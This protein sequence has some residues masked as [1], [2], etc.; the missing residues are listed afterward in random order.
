[1]TS[2]FQQIGSDEGAE[3][4]LDALG[5]PITYLPTSGA[6]RSIVGVVDR[7]APTSPSPSGMRGRPKGNVQV[8]VRNSSTLG[9]DLDELN[10]GGDKI[11]LPMK[12]GQAATDRP[13]KTLVSQAFGM[14]VLEVS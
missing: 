13:I 7:D 12:V 6:T 10:L 5:E 1:M 2:Q 9:I 4:L 11:A 3:T 8:T 14:L